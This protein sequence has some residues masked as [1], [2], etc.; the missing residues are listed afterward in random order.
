MI[1]KMTQMWRLRSRVTRWTAENQVLQSHSK[2]INNC[3]N[4]QLFNL[5]RVN[6]LKKTD[7]W[8]WFL[9][10][11][12]TKHR[13]YFALRGMNK[14]SETMVDILLRDLDSAVRCDSKQ[15][16][17][18]SSDK[19]PPFHLSGGWGGFCSFATDNIFKWSRC[20][21]HISSSRFLLSLSLHYISTI[22]T[23]AATIYDLFLY[24][25]LHLMLGTF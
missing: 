18:H 15:E 23:P 12:K 25:P 14:L 6:G 17:S 8:C 7:S 19:F 2:M 10:R 11:D 24:F 4:H 16:S 22:L 20:L 9:H 13:C 3:Q 1:S 5:P 21:V